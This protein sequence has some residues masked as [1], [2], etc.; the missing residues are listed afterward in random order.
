MRGGLLSPA[1][2]LTPTPTP[3]LSL[4]WR[5]EDRATAELSALPS[6]ER[7]ASEDR[8]RDT[9]QSES[10]GNRT[11][12][13]LCSIVV[14]M[15]NEEKTVSE[16]HERI[17]AVMEAE[18][19]P[20]EIV[21]VNDGST[22]GTLS[23]LVG[24]AE[25]DPRVSVVEFRRNFGQ[26]AALA[27]GFDHS[28]G[29]VVIAMDGD[30]EN[31]PEDIPQFLKLM[32]EGYDIVSGWRRERV[33]NLVMRRIPSRVA[34]WLMC[35]ISGVKLHD[36]GGTFKAYRRDMLEHVRLY[37]EMHR[38]IPALAS[39]AGARV[40][41]IPV[42]HRIRPHG[43]SNYGISRTLRVIMDLVTVKFLL[44]YMTRP[45]HLF[46][47]AGLV[48][49]GLGCVTELYVLARKVFSGV[50][51]M[52]AHGPLMILGVVLLLMGM[53]CFMTGLLGEVL[54]RT[55]HEATGRSIYTVRKV[56]RGTSKRG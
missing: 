21:F 13:G 8:M 1:S 51:V 43:K 48:L 2:I 5:G 6:R 14:P 12:P 50:H 53:L 16:L 9:S 49:F 35:R 42:R 36:F 45:L 18:H 19:R 56:H 26:T 41:E 29:E 54:I 15:Y 40:T 33:D 44:S 11:T 23:A 32:D 3:T 4:Q 34:N 27:A 52:T 30:L 10:T 47:L 25:K 20:Y 39:A 55:Y 31:A 7:E 24:L 46:G 28:S 22:D 37:G 17:A 38:F